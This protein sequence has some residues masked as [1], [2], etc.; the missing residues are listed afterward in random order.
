MVIK[1]PT[2]LEKTI[3]ELK[4]DFSKEVESLKKNQLE[5]KNSI[6]EIKNT[7]ERMNTRG[8]RRMD[9]PPGRQ[10]NEK[11]SSWTEEGR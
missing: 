7:L 3:A 2:G 10:S 6:D 9:Q 4:V 8:C 5:M 11:H 1:I